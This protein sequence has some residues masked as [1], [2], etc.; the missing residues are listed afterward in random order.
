MIATMRC[1]EFGLQAEFLFPRMD[2]PKG[3][4]PNLQDICIA[5]STEGRRVA[6]VPTLLPAKFFKPGK[7]LHDVRDIENRSQAFDVQGYL[8][9]RRELASKSIIRRCC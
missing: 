6:P 7:A 4:T 8:N 2:P 9:L 5:H 1:L 3:G